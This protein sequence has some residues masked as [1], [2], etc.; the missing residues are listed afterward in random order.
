MLS[1]IREIIVLE[2]S[3]SLCSDVGEKFNV[4]ALKNKSNS[5]ETQVFNLKRKNEVIYVK[6]YLHQNSYFYH[7]ETRRGENKRERE[8]EKKILVP[9]IITQNFLISLIF[10]LA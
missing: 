8:R 10:F 5:L 3:V 7:I 9:E 6:A 1:C 4:L 2:S